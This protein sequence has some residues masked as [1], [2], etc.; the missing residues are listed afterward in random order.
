MQQRRKDAAAKAEDLAE[1]QRLRLL[2][3]E[4]IAEANR[5]LVGFTVPPSDLSVTSLWASGHLGPKLVALLSCAAAAEPSLQ[6]HLEHRTQGAQMQTTIVCR[7]LPSQL[8][9]G[10][11]ADQ[12]ILTCRACFTIA[13]K[14]LYP[15]MEREALWAYAT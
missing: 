3:K 6:W 15:H 11:R 7:I 5:L 10:L 9:L 1:Q 2:E 4:R 12:H 8:Y 14:A 13:I